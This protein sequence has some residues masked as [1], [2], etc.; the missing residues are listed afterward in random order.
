LGQRFFGDPK[1]V[2][3]P[4]EKWGKTWEKWGKTWKK[5]ETTWEKPGKNGAN[6]DFLMLLLD[7]LIGL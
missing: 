5:H 3:K 1:M 2:E 4:G 6:L 7:L